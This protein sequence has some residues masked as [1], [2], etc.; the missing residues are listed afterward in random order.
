MEKFQQ[1]WYDTLKR[2]AASAKE[3]NS[4]AIKHNIVKKNVDT[5]V[6][7]SVSPLLQEKKQGPWIGRVLILGSSLQRGYSSFKLSE[8]R[9][10][11]SAV[12]FTWKTALAE[13][14][15]ITDDFFHRTAARE[16][17]KERKEAGHET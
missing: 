15:K 13:G 8:F 14:P 1:G 11:V 9:L 10:N 5:E 6:H 2:E 4:S 7:F 17:Q 12:T 16:K 3:K